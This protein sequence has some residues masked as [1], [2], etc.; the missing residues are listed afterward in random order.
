[1]ISG[2]PLCVLGLKA[3]TSLG[4]HTV[5]RASWTTVVV[6]QAKER[7]GETTQFTALTHMQDLALELG[8][9][10]G[11]AIA[12][13]TKPYGLATP[14]SQQADKIRRVQVTLFLASQSWLCFA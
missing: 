7:V 10:Q 11:F 13:Y 6:L 9:R 2:L 14:L 8:E 4:G 3:S 5:T 1:M 12:S